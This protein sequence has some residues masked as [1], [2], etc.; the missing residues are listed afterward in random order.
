M[1]ASVGDYLNRLARALL[2]ETYQDNDPWVAEGR[3]LFAAAQDRLGDNQLSWEIGVQLA[4]N[5]SEK[6]IPFN[7]RTDILAAPYRDDNRY[8]WEFEE[9][10]FDKAAAPV[11]RASSRFARTSA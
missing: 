4:H 6:R 8:F 7:P 9:F 11:T 10:D 2:D 1:S 3:A 5:L